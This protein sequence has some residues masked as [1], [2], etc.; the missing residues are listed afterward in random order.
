M[1]SK[2]SM[3]LIVGITV[4]VM[5]ILTG[6]ISFTDA[7][8]T[9]SSSS[10]TICNIPSAFVTKQLH[11]NR[12]RYQNTKPIINNIGSIAIQQHQQQQQ[13]NTIRT[14]LFLAKS[15]SRS[16]QALLREK[17]AEAKRQNNNN[18]DNDIVSSSSTQETSNNKTVQ[19]QIKEKND[20]I[21]FEELLKK[22]PSTLIS[23]HDD[24]N[25]IEKYLTENKQDEETV[26]S[27]KFLQFIIVL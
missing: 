11:P 17:L 13:K 20:R 9:T 5:Q 21:R 2:S 15:T 24:E 6:D 27:C 18:N 19:Q 16:R 8:S 7:V 25:Q 22:G 14:K 3:I 26:S 4:V 1:L 12:C 23:K 10:T